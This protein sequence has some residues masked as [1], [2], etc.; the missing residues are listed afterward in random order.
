[1]S[2]HHFLIILSLIFLIFIL[3][4]FYREDQLLSKQ[5]ELE[6]DINTYRNLYKTEKNLNDFLHKKIEL[7]IELKKKKDNI[8]DK[9]LDT[10]IELFES[11]AKDLMPRN[12]YKYSLQEIVNILKKYQQQNKDDKNE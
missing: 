4:W 12:K 9:S 3:L 2:I 6:I 8:H 11:L 7:I 10:M 1:M 5:R